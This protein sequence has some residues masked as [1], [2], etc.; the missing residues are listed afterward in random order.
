MSNALNKK[1]IEFL[2]RGT[3]GTWSYNHATGFVDVE[4]NFAYYEIRSRLEDFKGIKFNKVSGNFS[5]S[6]EKLTSLEGAPQKVGGD[7]NCS[8]NKLTSLA[9]GPKEVGGDF[10]CEYN[11]LTSLEGAPKKVGGDFICLNNSLTN[12]EGAPQEVGGVFNCSGNNLTSLK[13]APQE[14][15]E[16]FYCDAFGL[17]EEGEWNLNIWINVLRKE[18]IEAQ[19]IISPFLFDM[20]NKEIAKDYEGT[21]TN[22]KEIWNEEVLKKNQEDYMPKI[23]YWRGKLND[24]IQD[25]DS[26]E[27]LYAADKLAYFIERQKEVFHGENRTRLF[28]S[29]FIGLFD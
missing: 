25:M 13:G 21:I 6:E 7:F 1:Q 16:Y 19:K 8:W 10:N 27:M 2:N 11:K 29:T 18:N 20:V 14:V 26:K 24:A 23:L 28:L 5:C 15:G 4:G 17:R 3:E 22:L 9:G 12:L